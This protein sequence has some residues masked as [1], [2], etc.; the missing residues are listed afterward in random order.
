MIVMKIQ[1]S[2]LA[3]F[4]AVAAIGVQPAWAHIT[5]AAKTATVG[6]GYM[7]VLR[8]PHGCDGAATTAIRVQIPTGVYG[9]KPQPK[10]GWKLEVSSGKYQVPFTNKGSQLAEGV[11]QVS[12]TGGN[13]LDAY[14][15]EF[16]LSTSLADSLTPGSPLY[17]P[18]VQECEGGKADRWI[19]IPAAG[20]V[21]DDYKNPAPS[22]T[23]QKAQ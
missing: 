3:A 13:L 16:V 15:D 9:V 12:W 22:L 5:L 11:T 18:V 23:L 14:Y 17:F 19:E 8:V 7:A 21:A 20:K 1:T 4:A 6:S 10:A 2:A